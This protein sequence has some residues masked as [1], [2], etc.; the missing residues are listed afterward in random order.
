MFYYQSMHKSFEDKE[1][2]KH[3]SN[4]IRFFS[5]FLVESYYLNHLLFKQA[6]FV[7][8]KL[9]FWSFSTW[10][11]FFLSTPFYSNMSFFHHFSFN[12]QQSFFEENEYDIHFFIQNKTSFYFGKQTEWKIIF[13][14]FFRNSKHIFFDKSERIFSNSNDVIKFIDTKTKKLFFFQFSYRK[15]QHT[16]ICFIINLQKKYYNRG[17]SS[18]VLN[19]G[20]FTKG[21]A[22]PKASSLSSL[23]AWFQLHID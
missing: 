20:N 10:Y 15:P 1:R 13:L 16:C 14:Y 19:F 22:L 6:F 9:F 2:K 23:H 5:F 11:I 18:R 4:L 3:I 7:K 12:T 8:K 21:M 17:V